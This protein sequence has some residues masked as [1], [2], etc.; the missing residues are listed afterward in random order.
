[1]Q[2]VSLSTGLLKPSESGV[3]IGMR[4]YAHWSDQHFTFNDYD[5]FD[6]CVDYV[7]FTN[8]YQGTDIWLYLRGYMTG[9]NW[10]CPVF[11]VS[12]CFKLHIHITCYKKTIF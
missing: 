3:R 4:R 12:F 5:K 2:C 6:N 11:K 8:V 9:G 1:M 10:T 7:D